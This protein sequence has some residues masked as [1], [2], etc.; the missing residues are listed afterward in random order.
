M[1][2]IE[3]INCPNCGSENLLVITEIE[4]DYIK[5]SCTVCNKNYGIEIKEEKNV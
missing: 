1:K 4:D 3:G 2:R 5:V